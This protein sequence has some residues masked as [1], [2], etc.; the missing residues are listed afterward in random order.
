MAYKFPYVNFH[1]FNLD[2]LVKKV[3]SAVYY[4]NNN[5]PD[6]YGNVNITVTGGVKTVNGFG[7]DAAGEVKAGTVRSVNGKSPMSLPTPGAIT[8]TASDVGALPSSTAIPAAATN[9]PSDLGTAYVGT[10]TKYAR[11]DHVHKMPTATDVGALPNS[12]TIPQAGLNV[13]EDLGTATRGTSTRY[14]RQDHVHNMPTAADVGAL[15][16]S[17]LIPAAA[18]SNPQDLGTTAVGTSTKYAREDHVHNMPPYG[19]QTNITTGTADLNDYKT[20][21]LYYFSTGVTIS[22]Q[23]NNAVDGWLTVYVTPTNTVKQ[24]WQRVGSNPTNFKDFYMR[25][26]A[27]GAWGSWFKI[28]PLSFNDVLPTWDTLTKTYTTNTYVAETAFNRCMAYSDGSS[29][30]FYINL[31]VDASPG[32][33]FREIGKFTLPRNLIDSMTLVIASQSNLSNLLL[34]ISSDGKVTIY[35]AGSATGWYRTITSIPLVN[36]S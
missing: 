1:D 33:T 15:P 22:N 3:R 36:Q 26:Y 9:L 4:V 7:P 12:T 10:S 35:S 24:V 2:W 6:E 29:V 16:D 28:A 8:L 32:T 30:I 19:S 11:Q 17:T 13:P 5:P 18:T 21:G 14:A 23:P 31:N 34:T 20:A 27:S 25:L